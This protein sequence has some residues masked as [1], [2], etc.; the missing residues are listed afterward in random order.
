[1]NSNA[2]KV[3]KF[4]GASLR[5]AHNLRNVAD[6]LKRFE[7]DSLLI[8]VSAMGKTTDALE[9]VVASYF[10]Q[11]GR[12]FDILNE[13]REKHNAL[14]AELWADSPPPSDVYATL[15][16]TFVEIEWIL[17]DEPHDAY[18]YI[19]DQIVSVGELVSSKIVAAFLN[20]KQHK[21]TWLDAR[22]ILKTDETWREAVL[23]WAATRENMSNL[24]LPLFENG[25][26]VVTQGF[27]GSTRENNTATLGREGSDYSAAI[28]SHCLEAQGMYIWKDVTGILSGDPNIFKNVVKLNHI[29]YAEAVEMTYYGA[30]VVHP[31][32]I[33]PLMAKQ[34]PLFVRSFIDPDAP[35]TRISADADETTP[36]TY[37][38]IL[39]AERN[40]I[41]IKLSNRDFTFLVESHLRDVFAVCSKFHIFV[42]LIEN[43]GAFFFL[44]VTRAPD[45]EAN[46]LA[47]LEKTFNL[48][49]VEN[50][51]LFTIRHPNEAIKLEIKSGKTPIFEK[52][53]PNTYQVLLPR[54]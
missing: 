48:D 23:D 19:Y 9:R 13:I 28:F 49:V 50:L 6:I 45:R 41:F 10:A 8:V 12:A 36:A 40:Q 33:Q 11:D 7:T 37:P 24:V 32:T 34:I 29:G 15:N 26:F 39:M 1:M 52:T 46:F 17:E 30:T 25:G 38:P 53:I 27:I 51:D 16:D 21:T 31:R 35:G 20:K 22:D 44:S 2:L 14:V 4:G 47:E 5:D 43:S 18:D 3:F 54:D 42:N